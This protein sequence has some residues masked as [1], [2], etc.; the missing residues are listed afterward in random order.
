[1]KS[2]DEAFSLFTQFQ[3]AAENFCKEKIT[4]LHVDNAPELVHGQLQAHC[5]LR[6]ITYEKTVPDSPL[7]NDVTERT[8][9]TIC[10]MAR[11]M[12]L[13]ANM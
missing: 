9:L 1:M 10:S 2:W 7:Q 5:K 12:L 3:T 11:T 8:N 4:F 6:G 13:D